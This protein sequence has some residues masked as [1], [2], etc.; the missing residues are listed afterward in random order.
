MN[1]AA[2]V[3]LPAGDSGRWQKRAL[4]LALITISYNILEGMVSVYFGYSDETLTLFGFGVDSFV[5]VISGIGIFH[6]LMRMQNNEG[7]QV[8]AFERTALRVTGTAF[9]ILTAGL[10]SGAVISLVQD[11]Q[12][13]TTFRGV[14]ISVI[15]IATMWWLMK[16]K[17]KTGFALNSAAIVADAKCTRTCLQLSYVLLIASLFYEM[18]GIG[19]IDAAGSL[20]IA[21]LSFR[22]GREYFEKARGAE[23]GCTP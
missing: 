4:L 11:H 18:T 13:E 15:S 6:M 7:R 16:A 10:I 2:P 21:C 19:G 1:P 3:E 22:E 20:I 5:E 12:P 14:V 23:C 9:Y 17:L 8:D